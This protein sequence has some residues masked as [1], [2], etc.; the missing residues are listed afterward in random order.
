M[1]LYV[2]GIAW[3][4]GYESSLVAVALHC[5]WGGKVLPLR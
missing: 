3:L 5:R 4:L 2:S 1:E